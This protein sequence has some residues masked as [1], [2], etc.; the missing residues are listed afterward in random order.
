MNSTW[1]PDSWQK[2]QA[3]QQPKY[4][5]AQELAAAIRQLNTLPPLVTAWEVDRLRSQ[6]AAAEEGKAFVRSS[7]RLESS[8]Y[9]TERAQ[10]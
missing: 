6:L 2:R 9:S 7:K 1:T 4:D 8:R 5:N 10:L 3:Q